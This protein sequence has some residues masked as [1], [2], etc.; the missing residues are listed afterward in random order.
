MDTQTETMEGA[1]MAPNSLAANALGRLEA[2]IFAPNPG[3]PFL[4]H[5]LNAPE[6]NCLTRTTA[7]QWLA[8]D[9]TVWLD[10]VHRMRDCPQTF[11]RGSLELIVADIATMTRACS[12]FLSRPASSR[13]E[14]KWADDQE[15]EQEHGSPPLWEE[16]HAGLSAA[17]LDAM[18]QEKRTRAEHRVH[19]DVAEI[20][21][22][23][24]FEKV[25]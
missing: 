4:L 6:G 23:I 19:R 5:V 15:F 11:T 1:A 24:R 3:G 22:A 13:V 7:V 10:L 17:L 18:C 20:L 21:K 9:H 14:I 16:I 25:E 12:R 8:E 2:Q